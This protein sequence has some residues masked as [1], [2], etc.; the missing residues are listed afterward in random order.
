MWLPRTSHCSSHLS[1]QM[2]LP[3]APLVLGCPSKKRS[4]LC[5]QTQ[6]FCTCC[7]FCLA[8]TSLRS[9]MPPL[10]QAFCHPDGHGLRPLQ[11]PPS[12]WRLLYFPPSLPEGLVFM[13]VH[14]YIYSWPRKCTLMCTHTAACTLPVPWGAVA[15]PSCRPTPGLRME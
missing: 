10:W 1:P 14:I 7:S 9:S 6:G 13:Y 11:L 15:C 3:R 5:F 4:S 12:P 2:H 8:C